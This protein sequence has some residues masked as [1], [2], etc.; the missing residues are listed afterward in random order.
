MKY[1]MTPEQRAE[2]TERRALLRANAVAKV[3]ELRQW[4]QARI[5]QAEKRAKET[6]KAQRKSRLTESRGVDRVP[7]RLRGFAITEDL[8]LVG[9]R[10]DTPL[11][12]PDDLHPSG[13]YASRRAQGQRGH[14]RS[15]RR[16]QLPGAV[17]RRLERRR[18]AWLS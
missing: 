14:Q 1:K 11:A 18:K 13:N 3:D 16:R 12:H 17:A 10:R 2:R 8:H 6:R 5:E 4:R 7:A 15:P 9:K